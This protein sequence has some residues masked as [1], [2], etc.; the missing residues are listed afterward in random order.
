[1]RQRTKNADQGQPRRRPTSS[2]KIPVEPNI[3][4]PFRYLPH[5]RVQATGIVADPN[6]PVPTPKTPAQGRFSLRLSP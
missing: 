1:M 4:R 2:A 3:I 5:T 6:S